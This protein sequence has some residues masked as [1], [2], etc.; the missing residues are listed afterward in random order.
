[1]GVCRAACTAAGAS[2]NP[3]F[4]RP[5]LDLIATEHHEWLLREASRAAESLEAGFELLEVWAERLADQR[6][7]PLALDALQAVLEV[8]AGK[9][10]RSHR[11]QPP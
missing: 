1:L 4:L 7:Y 8:P 6:L 2:G 5:L 10:L 9:P 11:S 3:E